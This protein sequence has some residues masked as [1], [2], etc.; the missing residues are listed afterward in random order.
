MILMEKVLEEI[1]FLLGV[2]IR[3]VQQILSERSFEIF[4]SD[5]CDF[6]SHVSTILLKSPN[7]RNFPDVATFAFFCNDIIILSIVKSPL[8]FLLMF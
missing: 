1:E 2:E 3:S 5:T 6:L 8:W 4:S 7:I